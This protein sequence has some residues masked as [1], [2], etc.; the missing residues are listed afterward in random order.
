MHMSTNN[1]VQTHQSLNDEQSQLASIQDEYSDS[2]QTMQR[3]AMELVNRL[4]AGEASGEHY[5]YNHA[6]ATGKTL[7]A[8]I[9]TSKELHD[10]HAYNNSQATEALITGGAN[11]KV[12]ASGEIG[13]GGGS[14]IPVGGKVSAGV[15]VEV[16]AKI[17]GR[18]DSMN[19]Q[20]L[21]EDK[22]AGTSANVTK[23][24]EDIARAAKDIQFSE[25]QTE[26]KALADSLIGSYE[27]MK[28]L[29][30]SIS[31][32][33]Q[34]IQRHQTSSDSSQ[35]TSLTVGEDTYPKLVEYIAGQ[36]DET[37]FKIGAVEAAKIAE[38]GGERFNKHKQAFYKDSQAY[39]QVQSPKFDYEKLNK[40]HMPQNI[41]LKNDYT[42]VSE[43]GNSV[44]EGSKIVVPD[45][46]E[47]VEQQHITASNKIKSAEQKILQSGEIL[48]KNV[49]IQ[50]DDRHWYSPGRDKITGKKFTE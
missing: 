30:K 1:S 45:A 27:E 10:S 28:Q 22:G 42:E 6:T 31:V 21:T 17:S 46:K 35:S 18:A 29:R 12:G 48:Q 43:L 20:S 8:A 23:Q 37:G 25:T 7:N 5:S 50:E 41:D 2:K 44:M 3:K 9:S 38:K 49:D 34:K 11:V 19:I 40:D 13:A 36:R 15:D 47:M 33:E 4:A 16:G 14:I 24:T 32:S 26:E 39:Q